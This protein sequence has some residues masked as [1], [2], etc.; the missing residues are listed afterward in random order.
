MVFSCLKNEGKG[1]LAGTRLIRSR[2]DASDAGGFLRRMVSDR[3][4]ND[5]T[6]GSLKP[7]LSASNGQNVS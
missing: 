3:A 7:P 2:S 1:C 5:A 4:R 6:H